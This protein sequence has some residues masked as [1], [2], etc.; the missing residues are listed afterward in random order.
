M[1]T[2]RMAAPGTFA[3]SI[4]AIPD[5]EKP[6]KPC[7]SCLWASQK[8]QLSQYEKHDTELDESLAWFIRVLL[9]SLCNF[10]YTYESSIRP[11]ITY[12]GGR[13][14]NC[15]RREN[16]GHCNANARRFSWQNVGVCYLLGCLTTIMCKNFVLSK[17]GHGLQ[18][19]PKP[20]YSIHTSL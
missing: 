7:L 6:N 19:P 16:I 5:L 20:S 11:K 14:Q 4:L 12:V 17:A 18:F 15:I 13:K 10:F 9:I 8:Q 1:E 3:S 2:C